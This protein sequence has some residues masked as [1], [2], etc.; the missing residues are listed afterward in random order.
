MDDSGQLTAEH[1]AGWPA[2][3][4][5]LAARA[6]HTSGAFAGVSRKSARWRNAGGVWGGQ[7]YTG[8]LAD[9]ERAKLDVSAMPTTLCMCGNCKWAHARAHRPTLHPSIKSSSR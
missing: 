6:K 8:H 1:L 3:L 5:N 9:T 7:G 2:M 4:S